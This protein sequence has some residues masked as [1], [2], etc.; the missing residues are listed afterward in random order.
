VPTWTCGET[1]P[2]EEMI[3]PGTGFYKTVSSMGG[4]RQLYS[5]QEK[6]HFDLYNQGGRAGLALTELL[7]WL[8]SG[9]L[10]MYLTWV[11]LGLL[12]VLLV[13]CRI[14]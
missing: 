2:N 12:I 7:R 8:H 5:A 3:V 13:V 9:I 11:T 4:L 6:G 1:Q 14:W 10:S